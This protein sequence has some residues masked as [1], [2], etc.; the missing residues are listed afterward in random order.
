MNGN[1]PKSPNRIPIIDAAKG[2]GILLVFLGHL[3][4]YD[5]P[6]FRIIFNFHMPLFF[7]LSGMTFSPEKDAD[8]KSILKRILG[9]IGVPFVFFTALGAVIC[10]FTGRLIQH[11]LMD[12]LR[13]GASFLHGDPYVGG[14]LWFLTCLAV[15][16][17]LFWTW[18]RKGFP[19]RRN[20][21]LLGGAYACGIIFARYVHPKV[22]LAGPMMCFS[23]PMAFFFF[24]AGYYCRGWLSMIRGMSFSFLVFLSLSLFSVEVLLAVPFATP[25]LAVPAFPS[26]FIFLLAASCGICSVLCI[27]LK[28]FYAIRFVGMYSLYYFLMERWVRELWFKVSALLMPDFIPNA[29][30]DNSNLLHLTWVQGAAT[31][32]A[33]VVIATA[34]LPCLHIALAWMRKRLT[35]LN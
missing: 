26:P 35:I 19:L 23:V 22:L 28:S 25:N 32:V 9:T 4:Y 21:I 2:Y 34:L 18:S 15:V 14:S 11:S 13:A 1:N 17:F 10:V 20:V 29:I 24:A 3:V 5:S 7:V 6:L 12:W 31:L 8:C 27:S 33:E 16:K 30:G